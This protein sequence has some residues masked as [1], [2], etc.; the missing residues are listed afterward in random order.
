MI[1]KRIIIFGAIATV[2]IFVMMGIYAGLLK[3]VFNIP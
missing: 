1:T 3:Q 2:I